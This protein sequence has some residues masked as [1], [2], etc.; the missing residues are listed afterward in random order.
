[1]DAS[2]MLRMKVLA[3][4]DARL[5]KMCIEEKLKAELALLLC[6]CVGGYHKMRWR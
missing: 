1:M 3:A 6:V 5:R 2:M 4:E